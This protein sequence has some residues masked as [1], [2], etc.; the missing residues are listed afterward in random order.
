MIRQVLGE[1][2]A[3]LPAAVAFFLFLGVFCS[4]VIRVLRL[5]KQ[6]LQTARE[7]PFHD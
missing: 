6:D 2:G 5:S 4:A 1:F 3:A 7:L